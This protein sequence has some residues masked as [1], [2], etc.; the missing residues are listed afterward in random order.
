MCELSA[1]NNLRTGNYN[2]TQ[3][4]N[5]SKYMSNLKLFTTIMCLVTPDD[6]QEVTT[7]LQHT[8]FGVYAQ[9]NFRYR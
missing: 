2:A 4:E 8:L 3:I 5:I 6:G 1:S 9:G 7:V